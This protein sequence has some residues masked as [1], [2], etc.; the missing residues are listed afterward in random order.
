M[1][2]VPL[3]LL[4]QVTTKMGV[5]QAA[6][7]SSC[8]AAV[9]TLPQF[10][11]P[12]HVSAL[13]PTNSAHPN[14]AHTFIGAPQISAHPNAAH[15]SLNAACLKFSGAFPCAPGHTACEEEYKVSGCGRKKRQAEFAFPGAAHPG[16]AHPQAA[17]PGAAHP[18]QSHAGSAHPSAFAY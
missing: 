9:L 8:V 12:A 3:P 2:V 14:A 17:H 10:N 4:E 16:P 11:L 13:A 1:G 5:I 15:T 7:L 6:V 18:G